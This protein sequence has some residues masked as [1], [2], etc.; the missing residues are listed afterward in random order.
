MWVSKAAPRLIKMC[1]EEDPHRASETRTAQYLSMQMSADIGRLRRCKEVSQELRRGKK[2]LS[3]C[4]R[5]QRFR[6][7]IVPRLLHACP[8]RGCRLIDESCG[9]PSLQNPAWD[10]RPPSSRRPYLPTLRIS[11]WGARTP[12]DDGPWNIYPSPPW[13]VRIIEVTR[14]QFTHAIYPRY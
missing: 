5:R 4:S 14:L 9:A 2:R 6:Y 1:N 11:A 13:M 7:Q 8:T 3:S 10:E 12:N